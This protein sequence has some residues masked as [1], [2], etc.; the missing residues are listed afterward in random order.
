MGSEAQG[1][2]AGPEASFEA[3]MGMLASPALASLGATPPAPGQAAARA[4]DQARWWAVELLAVLE[5]KTCGDPDRD[6]EARRDDPLG[7]RR[8]RCLEERRRP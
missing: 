1:S 3:R 4:L 7:M 2:G 6:E 8:W 5:D